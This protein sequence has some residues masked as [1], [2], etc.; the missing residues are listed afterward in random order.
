[1]R[2][3]GSRGRLTLRVDIDSLLARGGV[4]PDD[5]VLVHN[6]LTPLDAASGSRR[7]DLLD[8]RM[9][10]LE[11]VQTLLEQGAEAVV[12]LHGI[13]EEGVTTGLGLLEDVQEGSTWRLLL[14][15]DIRVPG[16][17]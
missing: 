9:S 13:D 1:M 10:G 4:C 2:A 14:I 7:V 15:R 8:T 16:D 6:R 5:G 17:G 11:A 3:A 12:G